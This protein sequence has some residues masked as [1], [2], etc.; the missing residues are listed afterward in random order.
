M[1][2]KASADGPPTSIVCTKRLPSTHT[3]TALALVSIGGF[4]G[5]TQMRT[6]TSK[7]PIIGSSRFW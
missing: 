2:L 5:S 6:R 4:D 3:L 1:A 7:L